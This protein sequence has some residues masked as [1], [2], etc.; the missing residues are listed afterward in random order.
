MDDKVFQKRLLDLKNEGEETIRYC[1]KKCEEICKVYEESCAVK[2]LLQQQSPTQ[3]LNENQ[4]FKLCE[5]ARVLFNEHAF[6]LYCDLE[7]DDPRN[8]LVVA[9]SA[10]AKRICLQDSEKM[11]TKVK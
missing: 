4:D 1:Q 11:K 3:F 10:K 9:L 5:E 8:Q 2:R 6:E 7:I